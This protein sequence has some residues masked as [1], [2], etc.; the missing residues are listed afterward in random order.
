[1]AILSRILL[2]ELATSTLL[3]AVLFIFVLFLQKASGLFSIL[4][5]SSATPETVGYLFLLLLP[6]TMPLT[7]PLGVLVGTLIALSRM[8]GDGEVT[9]LRA[10]G[11]PARRL[12]LPVTFFAFL[13]ITFTGF[14]S[15]WLTPWANAETIRV[16]NRL[17]AA[18]L[19]AEIQPRVFDETFPNLVLY[20]GDVLPGQPTRWR[21]VFI[22]DT[23]PAAQR[24]SG[25]TEKGDGPTVTVAAE[26]IV[27]PDTVNNRLQ[28]S[29]QRGS[30][31]E[32]GSNAQT[33]YRIN[34][35]TGEQTLEAQQ[36]G[37]IKAKLYTATPTLELMKEIKT[38]LEARIE[39]HTR[40]A[41]P[42]A[43]LMLALAGLPLGISSRKG[44]KSAA[45]VITV[46]FAFLYYTTLV[47]LISLARE[48]RM[49]A[50]AAVWTPNMA[51]AFFGSFMLVR[52]E[53][54]GD[55]DLIDALRSW[56]RFH[57]ERVRHYLDRRAA[58]GKAAGITG[59]RPAILPVVL[60][61]FI[62]SE[63]VHYFVL[64]LVS[65]VMMTEVFNFFEL[66]GDVFKN[67]IPMSDLFRYLFFLA[68]KLIYDAAPVGVLVAT[69]VTFGVLS[70]NNEITAFKACG[71]SLHRLALPVFIA[72]LALSGGLFAFD[73]YV[74][75][76]TNIIQDALRDK[77]KG[78]P[79]QTYLNP[80]RKWIYG[81]G[82]RIF[83][84]RVFEPE[85][86][87][88]GGVYVYEIDPQS[89]RLQRL[90]YGARARWEPALNTW[91]F[92]NGWSRDVRSQDDT[93]RTFPD[94]TATF[95]E[96]DE[97]PS[98]FLKE[99]KTYKQMN[100]L[101]LEEYIG[102]LG[103]SGF[104]T[105]PLKVQ[106]HKKFAIPLFAFVMA[107]LSVPFAFLTG[108]R[109]A[110]TGVGVS[111]AIAIAYFVLNSLF[112]QLGNVGQLPPALAAWTPDAIF[113][114]A[115]VYLLTRLRS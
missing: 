81:R 19:T 85:Q 113:T 74:V 57:F 53:R 114:L 22:A 17:G 115:G 10:A 94:G 109:G 55:F 29:L 73:H 6:A 8:S 61:T 40:V 13:A 30:T 56:F 79:A 54:P 31:Y 87:V 111:F 84:Y 71:V 7:V 104:N 82:P 15:L 88:L 105:I 106:F 32:S 45:F 72:C 14:C 52:L 44:G 50:G 49:A 69:L 78:K 42:L 35:P 66:L 47:S 103:Q 43:C 11:V 16:L 63:F 80:N 36:K 58:E 60:D 46:F 18:Q 96:L 62:L 100:Y 12:A 39:F 93:Y 25:A 51:F 4:V 27:V 95:K 75:V 48:G 28:M 37:E 3:G 33:F 86:G 112:E 70:K 101:Q 91:V 92:Q 34:F 24:K 98:W 20:V 1:M 90:I 89:F 21:N 59:W 76:K 68:P 2:A 65:F 5:N 77:I 99:E 41:L 83:F 97:P 102:E 67:Q 107:L 26:S 23:T 110:M 108:S 38:S 64:I 9:A